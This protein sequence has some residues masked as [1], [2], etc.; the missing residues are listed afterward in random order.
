MHVLPVGVLVTLYP[1]TGL[2]CGVAAV[3][4]TVT[5]LF[6]AWAVGEPGAPGAEAAIV[7][8]AARPRGTGV[9]TEPEVGEGAVGVV[10]VGVVVGGGG[11]TGGAVVVVVAVT[12]LGTRGV[13]FV[14]VLTCPFGPTE[15]ACGELG[16]V[17]KSAP[18]CTLTFN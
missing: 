6:P 18:F 13:L 15:K 11:A 7:W 5:C 8:L 2:P 10:A 16:S 14:T 9:G 4:D 17:M 12:L 3:H 1:V